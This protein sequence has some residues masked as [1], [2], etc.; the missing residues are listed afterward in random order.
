MKIFAFLLIAFLIIGLTMGEGGLA[1]AFGKKPA[2]RVK[3]QYIKTSLN[4]ASAP[5]DPSR[6][7]VYQEHG[8]GGVAGK[9]ND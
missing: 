8:H 6:Q 9:A 3:R 1:K 5:V 4:S 2:A 7:N